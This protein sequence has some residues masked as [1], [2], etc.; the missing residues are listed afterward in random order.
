MI[1]VKYIHNIDMFFLFLYEF[2][3][4]EPR[5]VE[6]ESMKSPPFVLDDVSRIG[7]SL[8]VIILFGILLTAIVFR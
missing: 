4:S 2:Q 3:I 8:C 1:L 7:Y 5:K 6:H